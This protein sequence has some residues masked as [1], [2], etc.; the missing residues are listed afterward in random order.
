[1]EIKDIISNKLLIE[2]TI[3][4]IHLTDSVKRRRQV[5]RL[6][7]LIIDAQPPTPEDSDVVRAVYTILKNMLTLTMIRYGATTYVEWDGRPPEDLIKLGV[8]SFCI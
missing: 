2:S 7:E 1:M 5:S 8:K 4:N 3:E 6:K